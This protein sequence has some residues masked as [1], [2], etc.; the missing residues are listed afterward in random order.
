MSKSRIK[1]RRILV[2][3]DEVGI[4]QVCQR[5]LVSEGYQV[6]IANNGAVA[7]DMLEEDKYDLVLVDI[8]TPVVNGKQLHQYIKERYPELVSRVIFTT[9]DTVSSDTQ[10]FLEQSGSPVLP[11]PFVPEE[12][13]AI[14]RE[15]LE[16]LD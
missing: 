3:E 10:Y 14:V 16:R 9:G 4:T 1:K 7:E 15:T 2:V 11:K 5:T 8:R 12:L 13:R 6:D